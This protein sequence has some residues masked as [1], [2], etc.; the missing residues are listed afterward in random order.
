MREQAGS[1]GCSVH[2]GG[3]IS[4]YDKVQNAAWQRVTVEE[5]DTKDEVA[6]CQES[7]FLE[8]AEKL[9]HEWCLWDD[10]FRAP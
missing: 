1:T 9:S 7:R 2:K 10:R 8:E 5:N 6:K 3:A 4:G